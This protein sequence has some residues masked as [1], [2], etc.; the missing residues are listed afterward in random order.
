MNVG[1]NL[2]VDGSDNLKVTDTLSA[3]DKIAFDT[4][5][6][7]TASVGEMVWNDT[8][9]TLDIGLKG[10]NVTLQVGQESV[11][12]AKHADNAGLT[13]GKAVYVVGSDGS[14]LTVRYAQANGE[15]TSSKTF[16][17]VTETVSGGAKAF[18]TTWGMVRNFDTSALTEGAAVWLSPTVAGGLTT[19]KPSAPNHLVLIGW[20]IRSHARSKR[21]RVKRDS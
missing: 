4:A 11:Q 2:E 14:N 7:Q 19:T 21:L 10:G 15:S 17:V 5:A 20:C 8:D 13:L 16:G 6:G 3:I 18:V 9:G 1:S 12:L